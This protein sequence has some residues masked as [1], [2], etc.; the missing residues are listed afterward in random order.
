MVSLSKQ[1]LQASIYQE[2]LFEFVKGFWGEII[3]EEPIWNW[4]M[5]Y[6]CNELQ[7][8]AERVF[9]G[10]PKEYDLIINVPPG[11]SKSTLCSVMFPVW[12]WTRMPSCRSLCASFTHDLSRDLSRKSRDI[13]KSD[14]FMDLFPG[15]RIRSDQ[16]TKSYFINNDG[17]L[18]YAVGTGG[19]IT[20]MHG[21]LLI[22][23]DLL[24]PQMANSDLEIKTTNDWVAETFLSRKIN[25]KV[26]AYILI[27][28]RLHQ[29]DPTGF[30]LNQKGAGDVRHLCFPAELTEKVTPASCRKFYGKRGLLDP[31]RMP[32]SV[33]QRAFG[34]FGEFGYAGQMLQWPVPRGGAMFKVDNIVICEVSPVKMRQVVRF[35]D[36]A[37]TAKGGAYTVGVKMGIDYD[38]RYW[39]LDVVRGQWD[40]AARERMIEMVAKIDGYEVRIGV[41]QEP[42]A[43][44]KESAQ[45]TIKRLAGF[46]VQGDPATGD[47]ETRADTFAS[48]VNAG[49]ASVL[50]KPWL[51]EYIEELRFFPRS[52][53]KDQVD[54]S[55][56][57]FAMLSKP[58]IR[59]GVL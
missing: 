5:E 29:N 53:Y 24:D 4:H 47:K 16:D 10:Q 33:L 38:D 9:R 1:S 36:K 49:N 22:G 51:H 25:K 41:E 15:I 27:M 18:R 17:G 39:I 12:C 58:R 32:K 52:T 40:A 59:I 37:G 14:K 6:I 48:Q 57:A 26:S 56:G 7:T 8:V 50:N 23:D 55:S 11:T 42:G 28:Q 31:K 34:E 45:N 43:A 21:H 3:P 44:G 20:G 30:R 46:K 2:S 35:W 19:S 13:V 54:A